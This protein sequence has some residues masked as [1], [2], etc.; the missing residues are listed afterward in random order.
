MRASL[1]DELEAL[2][3]KTTP[4]KVRV[5]YRY[6]LDRAVE[7]AEGEVQGYQSDLADAAA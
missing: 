3:R 2:T 1:Q 6:L 4:K 7:L 5:G